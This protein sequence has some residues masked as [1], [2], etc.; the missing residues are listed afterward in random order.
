[1]QIT[2]TISSEEFE[3]L[4]ASI[5]GKFGDKVA[6]VQ[7]K[8]A[9][10]YWLL[11][12]NN[13]GPTGEARPNVWPPLSNS[14]AGKA[15]QRKVGRSYATLLETGALAAAIKLDRENATVSVNSNDCEYA[16][17]HQYGYPKGNLPA[18]GYFPFD[19][20]GQP[21]MYAQAAV[22]EAA[23]EAVKQMLTGGFKL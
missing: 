2:V 5:H 7:G 18:R 1:M 19:E 4:Q 15:Y 21:T 23:A 3:R 11:V 8:M 12:Q 14:P 20:S 13:L 10:R 17:A 6:W 22:E 16:L 9:E